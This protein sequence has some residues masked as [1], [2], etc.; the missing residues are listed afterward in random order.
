M[1]DDAVTPNGKRHC[2]P[3]TK[4]DVLSE[5]KDIFAGI[6]K[7]LSAI[8]SDR[9]SRQRVW[10]STTK[11]LRSLNRWKHQ[12]QESSTQFPGNGHLFE[13][14][15][16][17]VDEAIRTTPTAASGRNRLDLGLFPSRGLRCHQ[18]RTLHDPNTR[19]LWPESRT[20]YSYWRFHERIG[21]R[22]A[23]RRKTSDVRIQN[24]HCSRR[25]T[26]FQH[27]EEIARNGV[28]HGQAS[29]LYVWWTSQSSNRSQ[30]SRNYLEEEYCHCQYCHFFWGLQDTK[31]KL[32]TSAG[33]T[34]QLQTPLV[35]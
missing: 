33:R 22:I 2:L 18:R 21:C 9:S 30:T 26:L 13:T 5:F 23:T 17:Q 3:R 32:S 24:S 7:Q 28:R 20:R 16:S 1:L 12:R 35:E 31:F 10:R 19:V 25:G 14:L 6:G 29:Q 34:T 15:L 11:R 27:R 4:E 8:S